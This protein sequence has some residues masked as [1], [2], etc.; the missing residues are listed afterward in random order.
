MSGYHRGGP[1]AGPYPEWQIAPVD[2]QE[3]IAEINA[4]Y[5]AVVEATRQAKAI[6]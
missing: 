2:K 6:G 5:A 3:E 1:E 4:G